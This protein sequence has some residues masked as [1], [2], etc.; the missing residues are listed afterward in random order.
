MPKQSAP[1]TCQSSKAPKSTPA[2]Q[3][4]VSMTTI[5]NISMGVNENSVDIVCEE[6]KVP[7]RVSLKDRLTKS[8]K[9]S[10]LMRKSSGKQIL[11]ESKAE[12][13]ADGKQEENAL[14]DQDSPT[15]I[16]LESKQILEKQKSNPTKESTSLV[17]SSASEHTVNSPKSLKSEVTA[18]DV[19]AHAGEIIHSSLP[20][21]YN[22]GFSSSDNETEQ[23]PIPQEPIS[24]NLVNTDQNQ[25]NETPPQPY[26]P[27]SN[28]NSAPHN[29]VI[30]NKSSNT[31]Q[32]QNVSSISLPTHESVLTTLDKAID[33]ENS[34][35]LND[36]NFPTLEAE[37][38][39]SMNPEGIVP[40][41]DQIDVNN[42]T[43]D[44]N[45]KS[46]NTPDNLMQKQLEQIKED[47][48][49][50]NE[51]LEK[52]NK[53]LNSTNIDNKQRLEKAAVSEPVEPPQCV[54]LE[55][56]T[57][58]I[59]NVPTIQTGT[60]ETASSKVPEPPPT[61]PET[62]GKNNDRSKL[63]M[64]TESKLPSP[65]S[66]SES[67][68][69]GK[70]NLK[71]VSCPGSPVMRSKFYPAAG[72]PLAKAGRNETENSTKKNN[73]VKD[74][75]SK[76]NEV[77]P[78]LSVSSSELSSTDADFNPSYVENEI[79]DLTASLFKDQYAPITEPS[80]TLI[81]QLAI[82]EISVKNLAQ[83]FDSSDSSVATTPNLAKEKF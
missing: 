37:N 11:Q 1:N 44:T 65:P 2:N 16:T 52:E 71:S 42:L 41:D 38:V 68:L 8:L 69:K 4:S 18:Q 43:A 13:A 50:T 27:N 61:P 24:N 76:F 10:S 72:K 15:S 39:V 60:L 12:K 79:K 28:Q 33:A 82:P 81:H 7:K 78:S 3:D 73:N 36:E 70:E 64:T 80:P 74:L 66:F 25:N 63:G 32:N 67:I 23:N 35:S 51:A 58:Q 20:P 31:G 55:G 48:Y 29:E 77:A 62:I 6:P 54:T 83:M 45:L 17:E 19:H 47:S 9:K 26:M 49:E 56:I 5:S 34:S 53:G 75:V 59:Q 14:P 22:V 57:T 40:I 46:E 21:P 30:V